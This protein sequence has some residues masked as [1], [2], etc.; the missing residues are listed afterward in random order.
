MLTYLRARN[1]Q[2]RRQSRMR[3]DSQSVAD[4][5]EYTDA[6]DAS[7][8]SDIV[9]VDVPEARRYGNDTPTTIYAA[10]SVASAA[11]SAISH[12]RHQFS[13]Q[14]FMQNTSVSRMGQSQQNHQNPAMQ[15]GQQ[16]PSN[17]MYMFAP[18]GDLMFD[19]ADIL[20]F[21]QENA[22]RQQPMQQ[23]AG[24]SMAPPSHYVLALHGRD[25]PELQFVQQANAYSMPL[26][27]TEQPVSWP[28]MSDEDLAGY[29]DAFNM[30]GD[31]Q[32]PNM[33]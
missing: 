4:S 24:P 18:A 16:G 15:Q 20:A 31:G 3:G 28:V 29:A 23:Q 8:D 33:S 25:T 11:P 19:A 14:N 27:P 5:D 12:L 2:A 13:G 30:M 22:P 32:W 9:A 26:P 10:P 1:N 17:G 7:R 6:T 21:N